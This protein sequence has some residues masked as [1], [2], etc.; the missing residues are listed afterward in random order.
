MD[1]NNKQ[2]LQDDGTLAFLNIPPN[3]EGKRFNCDE[4][5]QQKLINKSFYIIDYIEDVKTK[6]GEGR[7]LV[8]IKYSLSDNEESTRKFFTNSPEIKHTLR[9]IRERDAFP[10]LV[11]MKASGTMYYLI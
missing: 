2:E 6:Y 11:T 1:D 7:Y 3:K 8:K 10:R 9:A 4:I 5:T